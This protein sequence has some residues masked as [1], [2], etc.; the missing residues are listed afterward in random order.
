MSKSQALRLMHQ[1]NI[2][3]PVEGDYA[4]RATWLSAVAEFERSMEIAAGECICSVVVPLTDAQRIIAAHRCASLACD[5]DCP[6]T[7]HLADKLHDIAE[8]LA[9]NHIA[10]IYAEDKNEC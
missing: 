3:V 6:G 5:L 10:K 1:Q 4:D 8:E 9:G 2:S 7:E